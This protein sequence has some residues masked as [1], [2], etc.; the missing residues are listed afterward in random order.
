[1]SYKILLVDDDKENLSVNKALLTEAGYQ[2]TLASS[3][4][5]AIRAVK[6]AKKDFAIILMDYHMPEMT[7]AQAVEEIKNIKPHQ[8]I[9]AFSLDDTRE[10]M[11][12]T[13][14]SGVVDFLDKNSENDTLLRTIGL[15]C[16]KYENFFREIDKSELDSD[17][18]VKFIQ[19]FGMVGCSN[20]LLDLCRQI[21]K[22]A[23]S[24]ATTLITGESGTGKELVALNLHKMSDR[25][26]GPYVTI[27]IGAEPP[28]LIDSSLFGHKKGAFTG[29]AQD[30]KGKFQLADGGTI[31]LDEIGD[32]SLDLQVK[33]L[34]V[35]QEKEVNSVGSNRPTDIDVRIIAATHKD[36]KKMVAD[37]K[38]REDLYYRLCNI[39]IETTPLRNRPEDIEPLVAFFSEQI[40]K[41]NSFVKRFQKRC[42]EVFKSCHW[43]GNI[44]ELRSVVERHLVTSE[45]DLIQ[46]ENL[47]ISIVDKGFHR[48]PV[49][50]AEIDDHAEAIKKQMVI[51]TIN[52]TNSKAEASRRLG[53][54]QNRLH[55]FLA[56]WG[57]V[58]NVEGIESDMK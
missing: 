47:D 24:H 7:G 25:R 37:G 36:L 11:R 10:V 6:N 32:L 18:K 26:S 21:K 19:E 17:D 14:K 20:S 52:E 38:F 15:Y 39:V 35:L 43:Q 33:L 57:V 46:V 27:N 49:T 45:S 2:I 58:K 12:E 44:R 54:A 22:I 16:E 1:M 8:Q 48:S 9:L 23:P 50:M 29:A 3:G 34:R 40:C 31:F 13:F 53:I 4:A 56:K 42:V 41:E 55:Y 51:K 5:E 30:Q 28:N